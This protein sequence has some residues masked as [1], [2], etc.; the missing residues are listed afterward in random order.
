MFDFLK[1]IDIKLISV[2]SQL[3]NDIKYK[4][5]NTIVTIQTFCELLMKDIEFEEVG[6]KRTRKPL[7]Q[8]LDDESFADVLINDLYIDTQK[9][10]LINRTANQVKH[11]GV[12]K[13]NDT[14]IKD[15]VE[16]LFNI[17]KNVLSYYYEIDSNDFKYDP[18]YYD[19]IRKSLEI[20]NQK[21]KQHYVEQMNEKTREYEIALSNAISQKEILEKRIKE[22]EKEKDN[23][24]EQ[25]DNLD[26]LETQLRL[27]DNKIAELRQSKAKIEEELNEKSFEEKKKLEKEIKLLKS[28][29]FS[30]KEEIEE[31][32][33]KDIIDPK[34]KIDRDSKILEEKNQE[35]EELKAL[36][37]NQEMVKNEQ[38]FKLYKHN[39]LQLGFSSSYVDDDSFFVITG[40]SR[41]V[42]STS[43]YKSFYAV[44]NNILQRGIQIKQ[45]NSLQEKKLSDDELKVVYRLELVILSLIR[46]NKLKDKY[47]NLNYINGDEKLLK[48]ACEDII[49]WLKLITSISK[50][51]YIEPELNLKTDDYLDE[52]INIKYDNK[53][54]YDN[55]VYN[56]LDCVLVDEEDND[57]FF[58]LWIDDFIDYNVSKSK[59]QKLEYLLFELFGFEHF[60]DGQYEILEHTMNGNNT[61]GILPTGGGKSLIYQ[62]ASLLEPKI[63]IV[64]DPINSLIK[65]QI[66]GLSKK[67]GITRCLN[68]TSSNKNRVVDERKLRKGNAM[69]VFL[70]P[71]RFQIEGFRQIMMGLSFNQSVERI[72]LDEVHCL[73]EWGHDF[74]IP[75]LMLADTLKTYCGNN[76]KYLGLTATA[77]ASVIND[78]IVELGMDMKDVVFLKHLRRKNLTFHFMNFDQQSDMSKAL[79]NQVENVKTELNGNKTNSMIIFCRTKSGLSP[80]SIDN[81]YGLLQD[82]YGSVLETYY[83]NLSTEAKEKSQDNF[84][85]NNKSV[86]IATKAFGMGIDKPN[87]RCTVHYGIPNSFEAFYQEAGRAGRDK[88]PA[89]C[90]IYTYKYSQ[91]DKQNI[92]EFFSDDADVPKMKRISDYL[93][94]ADLNPNLWLFTNGLLSP[95]EEA[96]ATYSLYKRLIS[97]NDINNILLP[98]NSNWDNEKILYILH[99]LG[100]VTNWEKNYST[101]LLTVHLSSYYDD[102]NYIK[103]EANKYISQYKDFKETHDKIESITSINQLANL[104]FI[105]R[106]WYFN[107]FILG[108]KNQLYNMISKIRDFSNRE[109][110]EEI[111]KQIDSYFDLTNIIFDTEEGYSLKFENESFTDIIEYIADIESDL[112]DKRQIEMER[113]LES[114]TTSNISLYTALLFLKKGEFN[115]RNGKQRFEF[116][117]KEANDADKVEIMSALA[118][119][120]YP[121]LSSDRKEMLLSTLYN[122]DYPRL[123]SV[124]LEHVKEDEINKKYWISYINEKLSKIN[125]G[126]K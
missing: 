74:R 78:L 1:T 43:K 80:T 12:Y 29:S 79:L 19:N 4:S 88:K 110:S 96:V 17:S 116:V 10:S 85:N 46:N 40:V 51:E 93:K 56:I 16:F 125:I 118:E 90:Y 119:I 81:T 34:T 89:D 72:V 108:R 64:V 13:Y 65:D 58:S 63:T 66:D 86:L 14:E 115:S 100:I 105:I 41:E 26:R 109:C 39:A 27:K 75:Y 57:E 67:F 82:K 8:Y 36:L 6:V 106:E 77:A 98:D 94:Y 38:V 15:Y 92:D 32:R 9:L 22:T 25:I 68:L 37:S 50:V 45:S 18:N 49:Y 28:E 83:G 52:Y 20:D 120:L 59:L 91:A 103:N 35:I 47:W 33:S 76:V 113:M 124:F 7:G 44:L 30:L 97:S 54:T 11:D 31:L 95:K 126:G 117:Y 69:F 5:G 24:K 123:R 99:K 55:N 114:I 122:L 62:F 2:I 71:E 70:S 21:I 112:I 61:I 111:Q 102:I 48:I 104:I 53:N 101:S 3:E 23:Y 73:S 42:F 87:I 107:N 121:T 84:V 60:N